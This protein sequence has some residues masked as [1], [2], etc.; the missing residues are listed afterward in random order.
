M[1]DAHI[2]D[3]LAARYV[4]LVTFRRDGREVAT[5]VWFAEHAGR[6]YAY[7]LR[8][9]G[10]V[11]RIRGNRRMRLAPCTMKGKIVGEWVQGRAILVDDPAV[12]RK[13]YAAIAKKYGLVYQAAT[14]MARISRRIAQRAVLELELEG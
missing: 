2:I 5:P 7:T 4:S 10:K 12:E 3:I 1:A 8:D 13:A 14:L 6:L 11:K 9:S